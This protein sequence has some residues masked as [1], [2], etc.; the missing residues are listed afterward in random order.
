MFVAS[1]ILLF[2]LKLRFPRNKSIFTVV[3]ERYGQGGLSLLKRSI[4]LDFKIKKINCDLHFLTTCDTNKLVPNFLRF[5]LYSNSAENSRQYFRFLG[6]LLA[7]EISNKRVSLRTAE[8]E[9]RG[10]LESSKSLFSH[11]DYNHIMTYIGRIND[12]KVENVKVKHQRKLRRLGLSFTYDALS[13]EKT[14]FNLSDRVLSTLETEALSLGLDFCFPP[15]KLSY[16][17]YFESFEK[18]KFNLS[19]VA[20][21]HTVPDAITYFTANLKS[22]AFKYYHSFRPKVSPYFCELKTCL[23]NLASDTSII[24]TKPDKGK[25]VVLMNKCDY[26]RKMLTILGDTC[27]FLKLKLE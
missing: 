6:D 8:N 16:A 24:V 15:R 14:I 10:C 2:I 7:L 22:L 4:N 19:K 13:R 21:S 25:G 18:L 5:R 3:F 26:V 27:T 23:R 20:I 17:N 11:L 9:L 12:S 1:L